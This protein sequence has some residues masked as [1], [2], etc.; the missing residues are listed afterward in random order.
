MKWYE[1]VNTNAG[2]AE[3]GEETLLEAEKSFEV[4]GRTVVVLIG[5]QA[6]CGKEKQNHGGSSDQTL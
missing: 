1:A 2:V 3:E 4:L 5:R 6:I